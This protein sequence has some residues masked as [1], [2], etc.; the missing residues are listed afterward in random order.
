MSV[1]EHSREA[2][3]LTGTYGMKFDY[4]AFYLDV[5]L[6]AVNV[7]NLVETAAVYILIGIVVQEVKRGGDTEFFT[8]SVGTFGTDTLYIRYVL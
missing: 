8:K 3:R 7:A 5:S 6:L 2:S 1:G 4:L